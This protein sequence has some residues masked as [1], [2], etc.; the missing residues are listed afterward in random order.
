MKESIKVTFGLTKDN[1]Y[2]FYVEYCKDRCFGIE[3]KDAQKELDIDL[4]KFTLE[5]SEEAL[6]YIT[7]MYNKW[8]KEYCNEL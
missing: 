2:L 6:N 7:N 1:K 3:Q 5:P 8:Y 4:I